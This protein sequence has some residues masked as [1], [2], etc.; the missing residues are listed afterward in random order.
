[1]H[2][3][4]RYRHGDVNK[5]ANSAG[6]SVRSASQYRS[7]NLPSHPLAR[8]SGKVYEHRAVLYGVI[9]PG[10]HACHWCGTGVDWAVSYGPTALQVDHLNGVKDDNRLE[11]LVPSCGGCNVARIQQRR[12]QALRDAGWWSVNDTI[13]GLRKPTRRAPIEAV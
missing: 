1:M 8:K 3:H 9:G 12:S 10:V 7:L 2:Y 11:N 13:A 6:I 4:R 5:T